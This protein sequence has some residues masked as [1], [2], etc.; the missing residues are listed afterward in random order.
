LSAQPEESEPGPEP[1]SG[2]PVFVEVLTD[3]ELSVVAP[4]GAMPV[5]PCLDDLDDAGRT[6]ARRTAYRSLVARGIVTPPTPQATAA[7]V[8]SQEDA[9]DA[10]IRRDVA[11]GRIV[12]REAHGQPYWTKVA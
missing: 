9:V 8:A 5:N 12:R 4:P 11:S 2:G 10:A 7:A 1:A 6:V 3:E